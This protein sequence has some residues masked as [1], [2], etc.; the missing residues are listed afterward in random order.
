MPEDSF[1]ENFAFSKFVG[2]KS[3]PLLCRLEDVLLYQCGT[4]IIMLYREPLMRRVTEIFDRVVEA[5]I[6]KYWTS[7]VMHKLN[8]NARKRGIVD[9]LGGYYSFNL[10]HIQPA[11]YLLFMGWCLST[12][13]FMVEL[14]YNR[15]LTRRN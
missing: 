2:G 13:S 15:V 7:L 8:P 4:T 12:L 6:Y 14:L 11:F 5:Y 1:E 3:K 9:P 10:C